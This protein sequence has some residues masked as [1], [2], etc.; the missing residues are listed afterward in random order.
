MH[1]KFSI[2]GRPIIAHSYLE[3]TH[4]NVEFQ[5]SPCGLNNRL[6]IVFFF[7]LSHTTKL[8]NFRNYFYAYFPIL[9]P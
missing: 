8:I 3:S 5:R 6:I 2:S 7:F 9:N 4:L 1:V